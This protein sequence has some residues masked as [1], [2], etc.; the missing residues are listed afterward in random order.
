MSFTGRIIAFRFSAMGDVAMSA[1][2]VR[3]FVH[4]NPTIEVV[5]VSRP[6]FEPFFA[7]IKNVI[8]HSLDTKDRHKGAIG[9]YRLFEE[10]KK[11][12]PIAIADL[13]NNLR[14]RILSSYFRFLKIPITRIDKNRENKKAL[15]RKYNKTVTPLRRTVEAYADVF[16]QLGYPVTLSHQLVKNKK[17]IP[18]SYVHYFEKKDQAKIGISPFAQHHQKVYPVDK[19][20][21][22]IEK[23][24]NMGHQLFIFGGGDEEKIIAGE[25]DRRFSNVKSLIGQVSLKE[26]LAL[27]SHLDVMLSMD[28]AGMHLSSLMGIEVVSIWGATHPYAGFLGYGQKEEDCIQID[29]YC[30]PC[31]VYGNKPCYRGDHVCMH[32]IDSGTIIARINKKLGHD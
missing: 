29:L 17:E 28:S 22:V 25:W 16:L 31:S 13:H 10:L 15:T 2:V 1:A 24:S 30:R 23:L 32:G 27:I 19:M 14:S 12:E 21:V 7:D 11:Y 8:F 3:E 5:M 20:E 9:L 26:E 18:T 6:I 4:Q